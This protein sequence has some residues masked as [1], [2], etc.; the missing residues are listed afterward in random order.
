VVTYGLPSSFWIWYKKNILVN[1]TPALEA[2]NLPRLARTYCESGI[3]HIVE[4][5]INKQLLFEEPNDYYNFMRVLKKYK[6]NTNCKLFAY[7]LMGNH[8]HLILKEGDETIGNMMRRINVSYA[9]RFNSKYERTGHLFQNRFFS[10]PIE[11]EKY[12]LSAIQY[13]HQ[14]PIVA[15]ICKVP[16]EYSYSSCMDYKNGLTDEILDKSYL[17]DLLRMDSLRECVEGT[18]TDSIGIAHGDIAHARVT[19]TD[20]TK[21]ICKLSGCDSIAEFQSLTAERRKTAIRQFKKY[22]LSLRQI[23]RLTGTTIGIVRNIR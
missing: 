8:V 21:I 20:A 16:S 4:R 17:L 19:D 11:T 15:G 7:C 14:N 13:V 2:Q 6:E 18:D 10:E 23:S 3:Y 9:Q 5:G 1:N 12:L 22:N